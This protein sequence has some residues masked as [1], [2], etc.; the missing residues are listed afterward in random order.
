MAI[1][2]EKSGLL[3]ESLLEMLHVA[4][5]SVTYQKTNAAKWG[6]NATGGILGF[7]G[8]IVLFSIIDCLGS[9][10]AGDS[11]FGVQIDGKRRQIKSANQ[12]VYILNSKYF[13]L[14][15]SL[16][17]LD[18]IYKNVRSTLTHNCLMPEGYILQTGEDENLPFNVAINELDGRIYFVNVI[19]LHEFVQKA[20]LEFVNDLD[21]GNIAF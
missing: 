4:E 2:S 6:S 1:H 12:H 20:V 21:S 11:A 13:N 16:V 14:D 9:V 18:N 17:D 10:F 15:L 3:K 8:V 5:Y 7:A 19:K